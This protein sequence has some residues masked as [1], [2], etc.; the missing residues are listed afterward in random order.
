MQT[1]A[2]SG[3]RRCKPL[4]HS[5]YLNKP[6]KSLRFHARARRRPQRLV[7]RSG[8][9]RRLRIAEPEM[10]SEAVAHLA[11]TIRLDPGRIE[12]GDQVYR[13]FLRVLALALFFE[14]HTIVVPLARTVDEFRKEYVEARAWIDRLERDC[15]P[16]T[17]RTVARARARSSTDI[18]RT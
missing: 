9:N 10:A 2:A 12:S 14:R 5:C 8:F 16:E 6:F 4:L 15:L 11:L 17:R 18:T 7:S 3:E 13:M 1:D